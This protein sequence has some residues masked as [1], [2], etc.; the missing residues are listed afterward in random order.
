MLTFKTNF[1]DL[2]PFTIILSLISKPSHLLTKVFGRIRSLMT[3][4][5]VAWILA[6]VQL[7]LGGNLT[8]NMTPS[9]TKTLL[10]SPKMTKRLLTKALMTPRK[11]TIPNMNLC[12]NFEALLSKREFLVITCPTFSKFSATT[13]SN[14]FP[15]ITELF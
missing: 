5:R 6:T 11:T 15:R 4:Y 7:M 10:F 1:T 3:L 14:G 12:L 13:V 8:M 2:F 9:R